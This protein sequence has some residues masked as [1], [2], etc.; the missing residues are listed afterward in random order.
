MLRLSGIV[1]LLVVSC[2]A[3]A[4]AGVTIHYEGTA[5][6]LSAVEAIIGIVTATAKGNRW[7]IEDASETRGQIRR[8]INEEEKSRGS[9]S[10]ENEIWS[11]R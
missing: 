6:S 10:R 5:A 4:I 9:W 1:M 2:T 11:N 3:S 7:K 8:V